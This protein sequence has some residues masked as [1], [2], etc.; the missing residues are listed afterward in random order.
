MREREDHTWRCIPLK[1]HG[2]GT[3]VTGLGKQWGRLVDIFSSCS[4]LVDAPTILRLRMF[5][6][7][8]ISFFSCLGAGHLHWV[9]STTL[10]LKAFSVV[11]GPPMHRE[12]RGI[13]HTLNAF[14]KRVVWSFNV[15]WSGELPLKDW[16]GKKIPGAKRGKLLGDYWMCVWALTHDLDHGY[17]CYSLPNPTAANPCGLFSC[18][19]SGIPWWDFRIN[20]RWLGTIWSAEPWFAAGLKPSLE[21]Q[22]LDLSLKLSSF[23]TFVSK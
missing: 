13:P 8:S 10:F 15:L 1:I 12:L 21:H 17:K 5:C 20:A 3:P 2:D 6:V 9:L 16:T 14:Y 7:F 22:S 4:L 23:E 18:D 11:D 19:S